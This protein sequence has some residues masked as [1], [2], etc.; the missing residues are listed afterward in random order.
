MQ[1]IDEWRKQFTKFSESFLNS[2]SKVDWIDQKMLKDA[3]RLYSYGPYLI[4]MPESQDL[5]HVNL[6][7]L[8]TLHGMLT[9]PGRRAPADFVLE[10]DGR[11]CNSVLIKSTSRPGPNSRLSSLTHA[12][13]LSFSS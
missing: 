11:R 5:Y 7:Q 6:S 4:Q 13:T 1:T 12:G 3:Y 9:S 2:Y 10:V 8:F